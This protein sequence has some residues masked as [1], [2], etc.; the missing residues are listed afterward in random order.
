MELWVL[1]RP[2]DYHPDS[3]KHYEAVDDLDRM[4]SQLRKHLVKVFE[5]RLG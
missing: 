1:Q 4:L 5:E 3:A 2:P